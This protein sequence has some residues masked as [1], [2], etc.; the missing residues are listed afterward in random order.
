MKRFGFLIRLGFSCAAIACVAGGVL[1]W[2]D[3]SGV[4]MPD[5]ADDLP[6][7]RRSSYYAAIHQAAV[8]RE[9][10]DLAVKAAERESEAA[11]HGAG[12]WNRLAYSETM[13]AGHPTRATLQALLS[14]YEN[15][16]YPA[17]ADMR[18]RVEFAARYWAAMP[19]I[20]QDR[21]LTQIDIL[22]QQGETWDVRNGWCKTFPEGAL[23]TAAC[24]SVGTKAKGTKGR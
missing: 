20:I 3:L 21:T 5:R 13:A 9:D 11:P 1:V 22:A 16:P 8:L 7:G 18:W 14:G 17:P 23:K 4:P 15:A 2:R 19:D 6:D 12:A 10:W 24:E